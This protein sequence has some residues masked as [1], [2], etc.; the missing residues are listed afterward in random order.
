MIGQNPIGLSVLVDRDRIEFLA[1]R[2]VRVAQQNTGLAGTRIA[3]I[4]DLERDARQGWCCSSSDD[5]V[6]HTLELRLSGDHHDASIGT[7]CRIAH[8][9]INE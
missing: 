7:A 3:K 8:F 1:F 4:S 6:D 5:T 2:S 9:V